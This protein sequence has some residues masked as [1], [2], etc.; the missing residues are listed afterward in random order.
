[1]Y[2]IPKFLKRD[3]EALL[4][5]TS[6]ELIYYVPEVYFEKG[7]AEVIGEFVSLLGVFDYAIFDENGKSSG[8][9]PF[10]FPTIF[11]C[12]PYTIE[13]QKDLQLTKYSE[14]QDYRLL[15]FKKDDKVVVSVKVPKSVENAE[16]FFRL[17]NTGKLPTTIPYDELHRYF[18][19]NIR[20]NGENYGIT[21]QAFGMLISEVCRDPKN[22]Q[23]LFRHTDIK[24]MTNYTTINIKQIPKTVSPFTSITSENWD[25]AVVNAIS[26]KNDKYSPLEVLFTK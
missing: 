8:L 25:E 26:N 15:K 13:K 1:M 16:E 9:K 11:L 5:N 23:K 3:G 24:D 14:P 6:G 17:F 20:L 4:F 2:D 10:N 21:M 12:S 22:K 7:I 19:E 18:I